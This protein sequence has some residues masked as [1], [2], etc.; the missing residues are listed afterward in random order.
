MTELKVSPEE[1]TYK[2]IGEN[3]EQI[4]YDMT[5]GFNLLKDE[6]EEIT[7]TFTSNNEDVVIVDETGRVTSVGEGTTTITVRE[8][9]TGIEREVKVTVKKQAIIQMIIGQITTENLERK[10][11]ATIKLY[12]RRKR[13]DA[14]YEDEELITEIETEEDGSYVL[15]IDEIGVYDVLVTKA[16]YLSYRVAEIEIKPGAIVELQEYALIAGDVA[17]DGEIEI[18]DLVDMN[19]NVGEIITEEN[20][21]EKGIYDL[22]EDGKVDME[23]RKILKKNYG[24]KAETEKWIDPNPP[25][26][27]ALMSLVPFE[28]VDEKVQN[29]FILP[30]SCTYRITSDYG[31]RVHPITGETKTHHGIDIVGTHHTEIL[32]VADGTIIYAGTINGYGNCVEIKHIVNGETIYSF[33]AHLSKINSVG[34][35]PVSAQ[36]KP[37]DKVKKGQVIGLQ[38]GGSGDPNPGTSTG[39]HLHFELRTASGSGHAINPRE[40]IQF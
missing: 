12:R 32:S 11:I 37:G 36:L 18:D 3:T 13:E 5:I 29:D 23:D 7:C 28:D 40:Y 15:E 24:K 34:S 14:E 38:G 16:G 21:E 20:K 26:E 1:I 17:V 4:T 30:M 33:Y 25:T 22:N 9:E 10:N 27:I 35:G 31:T 19:D 8:E 39:E 2:D 6:N